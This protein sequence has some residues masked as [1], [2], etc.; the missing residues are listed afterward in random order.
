[1]GGRLALPGVAGDEFLEGGDCIERDKRLV[2]GWVLGHIEK[3]VEG[4][5]LVIVVFWCGQMG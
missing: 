1:M 5:C 3:K 2:G 4:S